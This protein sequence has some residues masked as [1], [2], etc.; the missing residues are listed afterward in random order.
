ITTTWWPAASSSTD[1]AAPTRPQP[2]TTTLMT[3]P[4]LTAHARE[5]VTDTLLT[6]TDAARRGSRALRYV[7]VQDLEGLRGNQASPRGASLA[8]R[9]HRC[10]QP[11]QTDRVA[12]VRVRRAV[13]GGL[14]PAGDLPRALHRR[15]L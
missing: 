5:P 13:L 2:M 3:S 8:Q 1:S 11:P 4:L 12:G 14:R 15:G 7:G 9:H 10:H 6:P